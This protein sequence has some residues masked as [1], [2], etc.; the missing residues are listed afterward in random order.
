[1][2]VECGLPLYFK[3]KSFQ[4]VVDYPPFESVVEIMNHP[5]LCQSF[6]LHIYLAMSILREDII[7]PRHI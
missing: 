6:D 4:E 3:H 2:E 5:P 1:M 7:A